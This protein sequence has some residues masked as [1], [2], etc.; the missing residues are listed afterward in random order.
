[1]DDNRDKLIRESLRQSEEFIRSQLTIALASDTRALTFCG[2]AL[3]TA[4]LLVGLAGQSDLDAGMYVAAGLLYISA[5]FAGWNAMPVTWYP[6]GQFAEDFSGDL[7]EDKPILHALQ[8]MGAW[9]DKHFRNNEAIRLTQNKR[10]WNAA[11][12][13]VLAAPTGALVQLV[14]W[15]A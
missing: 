12:I 8:E 11:R 15:T 4:S 13:A 9:N 2:L 6:P 14:A 3:A 5:A 1:M 7:D 10:L